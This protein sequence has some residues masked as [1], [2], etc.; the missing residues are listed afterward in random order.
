[1]V[2]TA[3]V[4]AGALDDNL[5]ALNIVTGQLAVIQFAPDRWSAVAR[6]ALIKL[7]PSQVMPAGLA[8]TTCALR[9]ATSI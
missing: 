3:A 5:A 4:H 2:L 1:M 9:P 8:I 6:F 7:Q